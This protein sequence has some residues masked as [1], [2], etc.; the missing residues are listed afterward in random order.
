MSP[1]KTIK[2]LLDIN[3]SILPSSSV[4]KQV[5]GAKAPARGLVASS[6]RAIDGQ[7]HAVRNRQGAELSGHAPREEKVFLK[8]E[9][10]EAAKECQL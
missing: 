8:E 5:N 2:T 9:L 10:L 6:S 1:S 7:V 3:K 4:G